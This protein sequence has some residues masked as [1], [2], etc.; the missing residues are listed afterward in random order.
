[1]GTARRLKPQE[2]PRETI[3]LGGTRSANSCKNRG[4]PRTRWITL[5]D[6]L[7]PKLLARFLAQLLDDELANASAAGHETE[8]EPSKVDHLKSDVPREACVDGRGRE[9]DD[10]TKPGHRASPFDSS[11]QPRR[12][13]EIDGLLGD[14]KH[15]LARFENEGALVVDGCIH[16]E[17]FGRELETLFGQIEL[18][19]QGRGQARAGRTSLGGCPEPTGGPLLADHGRPRF[20][21]DA[22]LIVDE[23]EIRSIFRPPPGI[24][25]PFAR[26]SFL[27]GAGGAGK[28]LVLKYAEATHP[29]R[30]FRVDLSFALSAI[31]KSSSVGPLD[32]GAPGPAAAL[33]GGKATSLFALAIAIR[34]AQVGI[35]VPA[36]SLSDCLP[37][38]S[39]L[40]RGDVDE[41]VIRSV[42]RRLA[43]APPDQ[44][45]GLAGAAPLQEFHHGCWETGS[46]TGRPNAPP[47]RPCRHARAI[48]ACANPAAPRSI[49]GYV[50]VLASRP[51]FTHPSDDVGQLVAIGDHYNVYQ[52]GLHPRSDDWRDFFYA[53]IEAQLGVGFDAI[54]NDLKDFIFWYAR[55]SIRSGGDLAEWGWRLPSHEQAGAVYGAAERQQRMRL[56]AVVTKLRPHH[57][58]FGQL[59]VDVQGRAGAPGPV[60]APLVIAPQYDVE[61]LFPRRREVVSLVNAALREGALCLADGILWASRRRAPRSGSLGSRGDTQE[62]RDQGRGFVALGVSEKYSGRRRRRKSRGHGRSDPVPSGT[63]R[64]SQTCG[65]SLGPGRRLG[66]QTASRAAA[67]LPARQKVSAYVQPSEGTIR[68]SEGLLWEV[69]AMNVRIGGLAFWLGLTATVLAIVAIGISLLTL[70]ETWARPDPWDLADTITFAFLSLML[71]ALWVYVAVHEYRLLDRIGEPVGLSEP[72]QLFVA[73]FVSL[74]ALVALF[75]AAA[76]PTLFAGVLLAL[77]TIEAWNSWRANL[78]IRRGIALVDGALSLPASLDGI[79]SLPEWK[80]EARTHRDYY[81]GHAWDGLRAT[82]MLLI[83]VAG[84]VAALAS[85]DPS[86][87]LR[88]IGTGL[89]T[90]AIAATVI[91]NEVFIARWRAQRDRRLPVRLFGP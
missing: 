42:R 7:R 32:E 88:H 65:R 80:E 39:G 18:T 15:E 61:E 19:G 45:G 26:N 2:E 90:A 72:S 85:R 77:K 58:D 46:I 34:L 60:D 51:G 74:L 17:P 37:S 52:L 8:I 81:F 64:S 16:E 63:R 47:A 62:S 1:M 31:P 55:E 6:E 68:L 78:D 20:I 38:D 30:A 69:G 5:A 82:V 54:D 86:G 3:C 57:P 10:E 29:G 87:D 50:C 53:A 48:R 13:L 28:T 11:R 12:T 41:D 70:V 59:I 56:T 25:L 67:V 84:I 4:L 27:I 33:V 49:R 91:G 23:Q 36:G 83:G 44:F 66:Q 22:D 75:P 14:R 79:M 43:P 73:I 24:D 40:P 89:A 21:P 35:R 9:V 76:Y 71:A